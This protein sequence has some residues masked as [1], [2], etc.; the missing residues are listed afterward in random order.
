MGATPALIHA[1][2]LPGCP[3]I[4]VDYSTEWR[5]HTDSAQ[6]AGAMLVCPACQV[7]VGGIAEWHRHIRLV[8]TNRKP[9]LLIGLLQAAHAKLVSIPQCPAGPAGK[10]STQWH[11]PG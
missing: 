10:L 6:C 8:C 9:R 7:D 11:H 1:L 3:W 2:L 5:R 4:S